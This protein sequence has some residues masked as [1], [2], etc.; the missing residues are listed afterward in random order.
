MRSF[1]IAL[2]CMFVATSVAA[3]PEADGAVS[4][5]A[6]VEAATEA[7]PE[8]EAIAAEL[9]AA[10]SETA[11]TAADTEAGAEVVAG[12]ADAVEVVVD[13]ATSPEAAPEVA[14]TFEGSTYIVTQ[15]EL[16][17]L[18][19]PPNAP[20]IAPLRE[21]SVSLGVMEMADGSGG[22]FV[23][24]E[25]SDLVIEF[26]LTQIPADAPNQFSGGA[27]ASV[28]QQLVK[29]MNEQ[30]LGSIIVAPDENDIGFTTGQDVREDGDTSLGLTIFLPTIKEI[31][32]FAT[33]ERIPEYEATNNPAHSRILDESPVNAD[34]FFWPKA[35]DDYVARLN[36]HPGR[37]VIAQLSPSHDQQQLY[38]DYQI[39]ETKPWVAYATIANAGSKA[40]GEW[41]ARLGFVHLQPTN[42]DDILTVDYVMNT[43]S[44][45]RAVSASYELPL[46]I[47]TLRLGINGGYA[48]FDASRRQTISANANT[49]LIQVFEGDQARG[50]ARLA[51][52]FLQFDE[53]FFDVFAGARYEHITTDQR[54]RISTTDPDDV[55]PISGSE[56]FLTVSAGLT[57]ER[58]TPKIK[59]LGGVWAEIGTLDHD[60]D[61]MSDF[62][63]LGRTEPDN[64]PIFLRWDGRATFFLDALLADP[65][66]PA[67]VHAHEFR[68]RYRGQDSLGHRLIAHHQQVAGGLETVRGYDQG[69]AA[70]DDAHLAS[71]EYRFHLPRAL[72]PNPKAPV[73]P[74]LGEF[75]V[76]PRG[77]GER[78]DWDWVIKAFYDVAKV[79]QS[80]QRLDEFD[81][82]L[83]G[84]GVG[85]EL[86]FK[87]NVQLRLDWGIGLAEAQCTAATRLRAKSC[88]VDKNEWDLNF[89]ASFFY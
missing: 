68:V 45:V 87:R 27:I 85:T 77:R 52:N 86:F 6:S 11:E 3:Q 19:V 41:Q 14:T 76:V 44:N 59:L 63:N 37:R 1:G 39:T 35:V 2:A 61:E 48:D 40:T 69:L 4:D 38:L 43:N 7:P 65:K 56:D 73:V 72:K 28:N 23:S 66:N 29:A 55:E 80:D 62:S 54:S 78:A 22:V 71:F 81:D 70:G 8:I 74:L 26:P 75:A 58:K 84:V 34:D 12:V 30:G 5:Q 57:V 42:R 25:Q 83:H 60:T 64:N 15:F 33:G 49:F 17:Y 10:G 9:E 67:P 16:E 32:S 89:M 13:E 31:Q 18:V 88:A 36:R 20:E 47:D 46:W 50:G 24:P 79:K 82:V 21:T 51:Y 53:Y